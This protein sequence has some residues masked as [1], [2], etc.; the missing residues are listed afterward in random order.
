MAAWQMIPFS[1]NTIVSIPTWELYPMSAT[2][3]ND[4]QLQK[5]IMTME[6]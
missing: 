3:Y 6:S 2:V 4:M 1:F 5:D